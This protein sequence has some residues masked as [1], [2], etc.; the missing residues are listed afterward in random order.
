MKQKLITAIVLF[1]FAAISYGQSNIIKTNLFSATMARSFNIGYE[2]VINDKMSGVVNINMIPAGQPF[3]IKRAIDLIG[4]ESADFG[5]FKLGGFSIAPEW[6]FYTSGK[7]DAPK[8]FYV[9]PYLKYLS[10]KATYSFDNESEE[11]SSGFTIITT[12]PISLTGKLSGIGFGCQ[13]G[14]QWLISDKVSIDWW[15]F[16]PAV[17]SDKLSITF[18]FPGQSLSQSELQEIESDLSSDFE[19]G[20]ISVDSDI[21]NGEIK[22]SGKTLFGGI[23]TGLSVGIAF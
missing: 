19:D 22:F 16:G 8:G 5:T 6:R 15:L 4:G 18:G 14:W 20:P 9:A 10:Y 21:S 7:K 1:I 11:D 17:Y 2:R 23:R 3:I 13:L 12:T